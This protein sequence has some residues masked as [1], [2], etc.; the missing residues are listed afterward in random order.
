M[1]AASSDIS[2]SLARWEYIE[3]LG[4]MIVLWGVV[5][6]FC[7][8]FTKL[9][10]G[11]HGK[12]RLAKQSTLILIVGLVIELAGMFK[13]SQLSGIV[14][15]NLDFR[16]AGVEKQVQELRRGND[17]LEAKLQP[18]RITAQQMQDFKFL[19]EHIEKIPIKIE[20]VNLREPL[21]FAHDLREMFTFAG[22]KTNSDVTLFGINRSTGNIVTKFGAPHSGSDVLF[23]TDKAAETYV[24]TNEWVEEITNGFARPIIS[25]TNEP[26]VYA[27]IKECF[28]R[29]GIKCG[30]EGFQGLVGPGQREILITEKHD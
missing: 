5:G 1:I 26:V 20:A 13:T 29:I 3:F 18:R 30:L 6:E 24:E 7:A 25:S 2:G 15:A 4:A 21:T 22:F 27:A 23:V 16:R 28:K 11:E 12:L 19:T 14:I 9:P 8:D 10:N 17:E